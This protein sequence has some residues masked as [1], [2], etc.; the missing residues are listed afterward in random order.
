MRVVV[1]RAVAALFILI[2]FLELLSLIE[3]ALVRPAAFSAMPFGW[4]VGRYLRLAALSTFPLIGGIAFLLMRNA[5]RVT[6]LVYC[7]LAPALY[8][9]AVGLGYANFENPSSSDWMIGLLLTY[10]IYTPFIIF[11]TLKKTREMMRP[12]AVLPDR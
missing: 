11:L 8:A 10:A 4:Q 12:R 7:L 3:L 1:A 2:G 9:W 5:G 6:L